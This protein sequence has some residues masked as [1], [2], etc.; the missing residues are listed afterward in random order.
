MWFSQL[1]HT[2]VGTGDLQPL[3]NTVL[4]LPPSCC[5]W[6]SPCVLLL[7]SQRE[8]SR[9][10]DEP[11]LSPGPSGMAQGSLCPGPAKCLGVGSSPTVCAGFWGVLGQ[12]EV[13]GDP[14]KCCP[15]LGEGLDGFQRSSLFNKDG[16][17]CQALPGATPQLWGQGGITGQAYPRLPLVLAAVPGS[18]ELWQRSPSL[19]DAQTRLLPQ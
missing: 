5:A 2:E 1:N 8:R 19:L 17:G 16:R 6:S 14:G 4:L 15:C 7:Y 18:P 9:V 13:C 10:T 3:P 11:S 12:W